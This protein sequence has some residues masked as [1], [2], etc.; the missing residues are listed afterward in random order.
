MRIGELA[1]QAGVSTKAV[2][3]YES[4]GLLP[5]PDRTPSNYRDYGPDAV[6]R[7][8]FIKDAQSSGLSLTEIHSLVELK[9][10]GASTCEH[11]IDLLNRH[12][13]DIDAQIAQLQQ[14]RFTLAA[15]AE[16]A[17]RL[18]H[19]ACTD[20]HRCHVITAADDRQAPHDVSATPTTGRSDTT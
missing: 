14:T 2:R 6:A 17:E 15:L 16:R 12:L 13:V 11:T 5:E 4:R 7:L 18:D 19:A 20:P 10:A 3:F 9:S 8:Q 1:D